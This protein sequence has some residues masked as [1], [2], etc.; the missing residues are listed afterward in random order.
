MGIEVAEHHRLV[1][2]TAADLPP[3]VARALAVTRLEDGTTA[4]LGSVRADGID[5]AT[6]AWGSIADPSL[7]LVH[8]VTS[9]STTFWRLGP[10]LAASGRRVVAVDLP[11]HGRT[12][13]WRGR[14]RLA[15]TSQDLAAFIREAGLDIPGLA[16]LGHSWGGMVVAGLPLAGLRPNRLLL[17]DPPYLTLNRLYALTDSPS[18]QLY[19]TVDEARGRIRAENPAWSPGD[20]EA[21]AIGLTRFNEEAVLSVLRQNGPWDAGLAALNAP[22]ASDADAWY[23]RGE[24]HDGG[25]IP[26]HA[27]RK[28][29]ARVGASHVLTIAGGPHSPQRTHPEATVA[30]ILRALE[31]A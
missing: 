20:V 5:W 11:G 19:E 6:R 14:Y 7:I 9:D 10:A 22:A 27:V 8:G 25:L 31:S 15:E 13:Q 4:E 3:A 1:T 26:D 30:A 24:W 21:K 23:I 16:V 2:A 18:E 12:G 17:L 29:A 28:L